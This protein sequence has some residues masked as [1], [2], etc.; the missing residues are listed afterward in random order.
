[1]TSHPGEREVVWLL[2]CGMTNFAPS[3][4]KLSREEMRNLLFWSNLSVINALASREG[5]RRL[6]ITR[7]QSPGHR[8]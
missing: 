7:R 3:W 2:V 1:M 8:G 6:K 4:G 5:H